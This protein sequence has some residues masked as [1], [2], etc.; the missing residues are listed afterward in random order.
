MRRF[1]LA[2]ASL[3]LL[4]PL[5]LA[6]QGPMPESTPPAATARPANVISINP[7]LP[8][9]G[10]FQGEYE[11]RLRDNL[12]FALG[13]SHVKLDEIYTNV[14][15]KLRLY[16]QEKAPYGL[17]I[18]AGLG[19]GHIRQDSYSD[20]SGCIPVL[21]VVCPPNLRRTTTA[22]S[23]SVEIHYQ[24][25]LGKK[26]NTAVGFGFGA[27]RYFISDNDN[28]YGDELFQA[29]VPTGRITIGWAFP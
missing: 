18:A 24:W 2:F 20:Y 4:L 22:P 29:F 3:L 9:A 21:G 19:V 16:P 5:P 11:R 12:G 1:S 6:A 7:F 15:A 28:G 8:L 27:K 26:R 23:F 10:Y 17:G 25:L 13:F 14:D